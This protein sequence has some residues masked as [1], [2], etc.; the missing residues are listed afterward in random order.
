MP[1]AS[2]ILVQVLG[3][4]KTSARIRGSL[5]IHSLSDI[6]GSLHYYNNIGA[7]RESFSA[8]YTDFIILLQY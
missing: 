4:L 3:A 5:L 1:V 6:Q 8:I 7:I 2:G